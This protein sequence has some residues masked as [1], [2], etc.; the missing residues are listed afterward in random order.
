MVSADNQAGIQEPHALQVVLAKRTYVLPWA[1]FLYA[2]GSD[3]EVRLSF[4]T[5]EILVKGSNL[6]SL[7]AALAVHGISRLKEPAGPDRFMRVTG[8]FIREIY[9][10]KV[11]LERA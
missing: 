4:T 1:Q 11:E 7:I 8:P 5:H 9:V 10:E 3:D 6:N 2:E